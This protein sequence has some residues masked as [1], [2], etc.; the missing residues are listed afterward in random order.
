MQE[1]IDR[2]FSSH[3]TSTG[4]TY[5]GPVETVEVVEHI[6]PTYENFVPTSANKM[7]THDDLVMFTKVLY[8][9]CIG[10]QSV[11]EQACVAW[12]I[13]NRYDA[14]YGTL[15][16]IITAP[17]AYAYH[18][19]TVMDDRMFLLAE[20]VLNRWSAEHSGITDVGRTIPADY[21]YFNGDGVHNYFRNT[22]K[23]TGTYWN[24]SLDTPY[25]S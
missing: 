8:K 24:Y 13:C 16:A 14:G 22:F 11:T 18:E 5:V 6:E 17:G 21:L 23:D 9:E 7:Y 25:C 10:V 1:R 2:N 4:Q 3:V 19:D 20:D 15:K 12:T